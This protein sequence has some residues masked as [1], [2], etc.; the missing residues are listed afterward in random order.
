MEWKNK[1]YK[2]IRDFMKNENCMDS[3]TT[4]LRPPV[5]SVKNLE[6]AINIMIQACLEKIRVT[7]IGD[8][9]VDGITSSLILAKMF[10]EKGNPAIVR[11]PKRFSEGY[12][13]SDS[14]I[15]EIIA[16]RKT[17]GELVITIDNGINSVDQIK[18]LKDAGFKVIVIDHH[19]PKIV[20]GQMLIPNADVVVNPHVF[21]GDFIEYCAAGLAF[22]AVLMANCSN[23]LFY[24]AVSLAT[25]AT[26]SDVVSLTGD[27]R[28]IVITGI[29]VMNSDNCPINIRHILIILNITH[30]DEDAIAYNIGPL[31][32]SAGRLFDKGAEFTYHVLH[33]DNYEGYN[34]MV[35]INNERKDMVE[36]NFRNSCSSIDSSS[37]HPIVVTSCE[38]L[39]IAGIIAGKLAETYKVPTI[40]LVKLKDGSYKGSAR[41]IPGVSLIEML[42]KNEKYL[43]QYG[44]HIGA[45]GLSINA[46]KIDDFIKSFCEP[47]FPKESEIPYAMEI[48]IDD[49]PEILD[50]LKKYSPYGAGNK[51]PLFKMTFE[52]SPKGRD[53]VK[54][55]SDGKYGKFFTNGAEAV[56]FEGISIDGKSVFQRWKDLGKP[57]KF[58]ILAYVSKKNWN[59]YEKIQIEIQDIKEIKSKS[60][61][62][63]EQILDMIG[64]T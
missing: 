13:L 37:R 6:Q 48:G 8:Y 54:E 9:D 19:E 18:R 36:T 60:N 16:N 25:I 24:E 10:E 64:G 51:K 61:S 43:S 56:A 3:E 34:K 26:I 58:E 39:G 35:E 45:A 15:N 21:G 20:D 42:R 27:N 23:S 1:G 33:D 38:N 46:D 62:F 50:E 53:I 4:F 2:S 44:G 41:S 11:I 12:G 7:I 32:N 28:N 57:Y 22:K 29:S 14:I 59:S 55:L 52:A 17:S 47:T 5:S 63:R 40:V 49:L 30:V 31:I